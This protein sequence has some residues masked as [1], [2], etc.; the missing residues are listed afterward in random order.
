MDL[1]LS[2]KRYQLEI[3]HG[4]WQEFFAQLT[5]EHRGRL[6]TLKQLDKEL[7]DFNVLYQKPLFSITYD[8]PDHSNDLMVTVNRFLGTREAVY[9]HRIVSPQ[10]VSIITDED[11]AIQS[12][13]ITDDDYA[14]TVISFQF[15]WLSPSGGF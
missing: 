2:C 12:C 1:E 14:Q 11:G 9:A 15:Q 13:T 4:I 6:V 10:A 5:D 7:G 3:P 8:Q